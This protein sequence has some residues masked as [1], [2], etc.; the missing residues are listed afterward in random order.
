LIKADESRQWLGVVNSYYVNE[1][2]AQQFAERFALTLPL[3][4][5]QENTIYRAYDVYA[6]P[7]LIKIN[8]QGIIESRSDILN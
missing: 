5:D 2:F 6:S 3:L 4:F 8:H 1:E 7:Y